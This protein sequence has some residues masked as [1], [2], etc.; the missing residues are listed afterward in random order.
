MAEQPE[1]EAPAVAQDT[2]EPEAPDAPD[3]TE[4]PEAPSQD[5]EKRYNDLVPEYTR[6]QQLIAALDGRH[7][8]ELQEQALEMIGLGLA[9]EDTDQGIDDSEEEY[10]ED[11]P[12]TRAEFQEY[13]DD[14]V[15]A[16]SATENNQMFLADLNDVIEGIESQEG[17]TLSDQETQILYREAQ[18]QVAE[19]GTFDLEDSW[20][21]LGE[22]TKSDRDRYLKSKREAALAPLGTSGEEKVNLRDEDARRAEMSRIMQQASEQ[23]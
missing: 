5:Y 9:D 13:L 19:T 21:S 15:A 7:G 10:D 11:E 12:M 20:N 18:A 4:S 14:Q 16:E 8:P 1:Q 22:F 17:R 23:E 2:P 6:S 3:T